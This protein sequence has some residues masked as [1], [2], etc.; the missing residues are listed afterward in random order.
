MRQLRVSLYVA[1][2]LLAG[3][4][5]PGGDDDG[6]KCADILP[7]DLV[8]TEIFA[9]YDAPTG[10]SGADDG[11]EWFEIYNAS[12]API[13]L[14][15]VA[16]TLARP[17]GS[18]AKT[19]TMATLTIAAGDYAVLG[20]VTP[21]FVTGHLDYGYGAGLGDM[22]N[23]DGGKITLACG[24]T[25]IDSAQFDVVTSG[26]STGFDGGVAPDFTAND[27]LLAWCEPPPDVLY[28]FEDSN[29]GTPGA[30]NVDCVNV[31]PGMCNDGGTPRATVTPTPGDL[32]ITE[33]HPN[34]SG[35]D[36]LQEWFEVYAVNAVDL[37][38][39]QVARSTGSA[40]TVESPDCLHVAAGSYAIVAKSA[41]GTMN[42]MLPPVSG[43]FGL[44]LV[45]TGDLHISDAAG[46]LLDAVTWTNAGDA[47]TR[48]LD[49]DFLDAAANDAENV[50]C[51]ATVAWAAADKG[52]P[53]AV[54]EQ[55]TILPP[56]GM[57]QDGV[58]TRDI[59][60]PTLGQVAITEVFPNNTGNDVQEKD[61]I[62]LRAYASFD[63]NGSQLSRGTSSS[64][65]LAAD[66]I[67]LDA[68]DYALFAGST[69]TTLN[70]GLPAV[71]G[72]FSFSFNQS[73]TATINDPLGALL[74][75]VTYTSTD[76][77]AKQLDPDVA[78]AA[79]ANTA[80]D[81]VATWCNATA[82]YNGTDTGTP[83]ANNDVQCP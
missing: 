53:A 5:G 22:F 75:T 18:R 71:D 66:C 29:F 57:C 63:L 19:H 11:K 58:T 49:P 67:H 40:D 70:G 36:A 6:G 2:S 21:E 59:V 14:E 35:D 44:S 3:A 80:N 51:D 52:S 77:K 42:G 30:A 28:M 38:G 69:E 48:Q 55:C 78:A 81:D 33:V 8:V 37:N 24:S 68:G 43:T 46:T 47:K 7:G 54:N 1:V 83:G 32:V 27:D 26:R 76:G 15:D 72:G 61:W 12:D 25:E 79:G 31:T 62:E 64:S 73:G 23:T 60:P 34:P 65:I 10:G 4:C 39:I 56:A 74:D 41:D 9:D 16:V 50:W 17:D 20:N 82:L 13:D 45:D